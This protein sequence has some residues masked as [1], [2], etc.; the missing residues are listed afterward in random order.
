MKERAIEARRYRTVY[1]KEMKEKKRQEREA[2]KKKEEDELAAIKAEKKKE[3]DEKLAQQAGRV[4]ADKKVNQM[5]RKKVFST[6]VVAR[7]AA[8]EK[9]Q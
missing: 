7:W 9:R 2:E 3:A 1:A 5:L 8:A 6:Q 4:A